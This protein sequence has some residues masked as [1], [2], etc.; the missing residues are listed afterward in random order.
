MPNWK[1]HLE[2]AKRINQKQNYTGKELEEFN[3]GS[4][5]PDINNCYI[6]TDISKKLDHK[7]THYQDEINTPSYIN[8][9]NRYKNKIYEDPL[10]LGV[11]IHLYTDYTWNNYFYTNYDN[12]EK[13]QGL[14]YAEKRK[15]KQD[16]FK[17][18][19]DLFIENKPQ[20]IYTQEL[21]QKAKE[22]DRVSI[23]EE[24]IK[25]VEKFLKEQQKSNNKYKILTEKILNELLNET[26]VYF[27]KKL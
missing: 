1:V 21:V 7:Y 11:Y 10:I 23:N 2:I 27:N 4:I 14:S 3:L 26:I 16:D 17:A 9:E 24:D 22:I 5:L 13:L 20:F 12:H 15:I 6:V 19:N 8:F 18:Y 25:K